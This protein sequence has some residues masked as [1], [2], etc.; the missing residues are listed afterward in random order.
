MCIFN[1]LHTTCITFAH[2]VANNEYMIASLITAAEEGWVVSL[3]SGLWLYWNSFKYNEVVGLCGLQ[4]C[5]ERKR[6]TKYMQNEEGKMCDC[7]RNELMT[8]NTCSEITVKS[9]LAW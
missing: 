4:R 6:A 2:L 5:T 8:E 1:S 9:S 7:K 3:I